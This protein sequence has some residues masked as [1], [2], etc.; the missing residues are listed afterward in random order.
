[1]ATLQ[2]KAVDSVLKKYILHFGKIHLASRDKYIL[3]Y[4]QIYF[5]IFQTEF[6][7][8]HA[9]SAVASAQE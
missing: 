6:G 5:A 3:Q 8:I 2:V 7:Q 1:M 9:A 4:G